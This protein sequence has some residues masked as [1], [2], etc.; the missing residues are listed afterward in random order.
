MGGLLGHYH[1]LAGAFLCKIRLPHFLA[2]IHMGLGDIDETFR[3]LRV[4]YERR[5]NWLAWLHPD[6]GF[7]PARF[8]EV[9]L[10]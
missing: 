8:Q 9:A 10:T 1:A 2:W 5:S 3:F 7:D 4:A 6:S